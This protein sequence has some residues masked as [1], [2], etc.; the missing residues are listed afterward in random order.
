MAHLG[1]IVQRVRQV[2]HCRRMTVQADD[3][4]CWAW[5]PQLIQPR[6]SFYDPE[7]PG[8]H[9]RLWNSQTLSKL[10]GI[11]YLSKVS[12][13][14]WDVWPIESPSNHACSLNN[15]LFSTFSFVSLS[16][17]VVVYGAVYTACVVSCFTHSKGAKNV[18]TYTYIYIHMY[19]CVYIYIEDRDS[20]ASRHVESTYRQ[21]LA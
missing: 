12:S 1:H 2:Q 14:R 3:M 10:E 7:L 4:S 21:I 17:P 6:I 8:N 20:R 15:T 19:M 11:G 13:N 16:L 9:S 5:H 18:Y